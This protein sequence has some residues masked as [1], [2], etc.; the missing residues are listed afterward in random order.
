M[1][2]SLAALAPPRSVAANRRPGAAG[3]LPA[4]RARGRVG[5]GELET[6]PALLAV[7]LPAAM[8]PK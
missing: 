7:A 3:E 2:G 8:P 6:S 1:F 5:V 4:G